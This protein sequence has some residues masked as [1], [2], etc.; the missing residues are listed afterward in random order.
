MIP[1]LYSY[2]IRIK[3]SNSVKRTKT[4]KSDSFRKEAD[5]PFLIKNQ[6]ENFMQKEH[7]LFQGESIRNLGSIPETENNDNKEPNHNLKPTPKWH[8]DLGL[9]PAELKQPQLIVISQNLSYFIENN[10]PAFRFIQPITLEELDAIVA[11][12]PVQTP[13]VICYGDGQNRYR[14]EVI[15]PLNMQ[16]RKTTDEVKHENLDP[17]AQSRANGLKWIEENAKL[18]E[19]WKLEKRTIR[20]CTA[21]EFM[22]QESCEVTYQKI[23]SEYNSPGPST[24]LTELRKLF[25]NFAKM[26]MQT[27]YKDLIRSCKSGQTFYFG[28]SVE[29]LSLENL[30]SKLFDASLKYLL[31]ETAVLV[32]LCK[33]MD[34]QYLHY[35]QKNKKGHN[36]SNSESLDF[37]QFSK[38]LI[39]LLPKC[40]LGLKNSKIQYREFFSTLNSSEILSK[41]KKKSSKE[42]P[43]QPRSQTPSPTLAQN[44]L[45]N[46]DPL[47]RECLLNYDV[48]EVTQF[49]LKRKTHATLSRSPSIDSNK[50]YCSTDTNGTAASTDTISS[51]SA[52][53]NDNLEDD[54]SPLE[55][56]RE[57]KLIPSSSSTNSLDNVKREEIAGFCF[58][59]FCS[60][61]KSAKYNKIECME[62]IA[63]SP[64]NQ[65]T[66][67]QLIDAANKKDENKST[68]GIEIKLNI[69]TTKPKQLFL[70]GSDF[71]GN[72]QIYCCEIF[73]NIYQKKIFT[74]EMAV[75][76]I[77]GSPLSGEYRGELMNYIKEGNFISL[78]ISQSTKFDPRTK[79]LFRFP[80]KTRSLPIPTPSLRENK[81][82]SS[83][84]KA[85]SWPPRNLKSELPRYA[86]LKVNTP[87]ITSSHRP[88]FFGTPIPTNLN[89]TDVRTRR[90][91]FV[92]S[93][94]ET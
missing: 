86:P 50:T 72:I 20:L 55:K 88:R 77:G 28:N 92:I 66:R 1:L 44:F 73:A 58:E 7:L 49:T 65:E 41:T 4:T 33:L 11:K 85:G 89:R 48:L 40:D 31:H 2:R 38:Q 13:L 75:I 9:T 93:Q 91:S 30:E 5:S 26:A 82:L 68:E 29:A 35:K 64:F 22:Q 45:S 24:K 94:D 27:L 83:T 79:P 10:K 46:S 43:P 78:A 53:A 8:V 21:T 90:V 60:M 52:L 54:F 67:S 6:R 84:V 36:G 62:K 3:G 17:W 74:Y 12:F 87:P 56:V 42:K 18:V 15:Y 47:T 32:E 81:K 25:E 39:H 19:K 14:R 61:I 51:C 70:E 59:L 69:S 71:N 34:F 80:E 63:S 76:K 23:C 37:K 16:P 57:V